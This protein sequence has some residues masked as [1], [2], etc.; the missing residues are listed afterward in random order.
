ME[1]STC[2]QSR[3]LGLGKSMGDLGWVLALNSCR[4][5]PGLSLHSGPVLVF[6]H[7]ILL[8]MNCVSTGNLL[9]FLCLNFFICK[10]GTKIVESTC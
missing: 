1:N 8:F 9:D 6:A 5:L 2:R 3:S 10:M 7:L 4:E